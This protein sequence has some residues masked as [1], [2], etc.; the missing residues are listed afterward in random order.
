MRSIL[1][2][3]GTFSCTSSSLSSV[4]RKSYVVRIVSKC[5]KT[6]VNNWIAFYSL[7]SLALF[8]PNAYG[9]RP[10]MTYSERGFCEKLL[11]G[12]VLSLLH[13]LSHATYQRAQSNTW[14]IRSCWVLITTTSTYGA[15][16]QLQIS[17]Y[18]RAETA[19]ALWFFWEGLW[20]Y[21]ALIDSLPS[22][23]FL[24][25]KISLKTWTFF[26]LFIVFRQLQF[27]VSSLLSYN[28]R[29]IRESKEEA[30][31]DLCVGRPLRDRF[32]FPLSE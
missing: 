8:I 11:P 10:E 13:V 12:Q 14:F 28:Y 15:T 26:M 9:R 17:L 19:F 32:S 5:L 6:G 1:F 2:S 21:R 18:R 23:V 22:I 7:H 30:N 29:I 4:Y 24:Y 25:V 3:V 20:C 16:L 27:F 31:L